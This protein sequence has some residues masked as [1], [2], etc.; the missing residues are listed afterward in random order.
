MSND[1]RP[2]GAERTYDPSPAEALREVTLRPDAFFRRLTPSAGYAAPTVFALVCIAVS[3]VLAWVATGA[4]DSVGTGLLA[5]LAFDLVFFAV[6]V[7]I[8]HAMVHLLAK[9]H[10]GAQATYR[11]A[12]YGQV[13]QLVNWIPVVGLYLGLA[14]GSVLAVI[15]VRRMHGASLRTAILV[16]VLPL[17]VA[18][19]VAAVVV[20]VM[21]A[22]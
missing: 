3:T 22:G 5:P 19:V 6:Y 15:G 14:Y 8:T 1:V 18:A 20:A 2:A 9:P 10:A 12:A 4:D 16:V 7:A 13:S 11:V 17:V 21:A